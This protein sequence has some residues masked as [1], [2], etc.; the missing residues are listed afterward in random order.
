M[1]RAVLCVLGSGNWNN[2]G[3]AGVWYR[4][5]NNN[6]TNSNTNVSARPRL[7]KQFRTHVLRGASANNQREYLP[8]LMG[9]FIELY[10][11]KVIFMKF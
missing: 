1:C 4:N 7:W 2:A 10:F 3:N 8:S 6:S 11:I 9:K 5:L